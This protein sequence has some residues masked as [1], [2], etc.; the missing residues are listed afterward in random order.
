MP[1]PSRGE[2]KGR[3][4]SGP[5]LLSGTCEVE[6]EATMCLFKDEEEPLWRAV[7]SPRLHGQCVA[8]V[9]SLNW[10]CDR[11]TTAPTML[12]GRTFH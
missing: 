6:A 2:G 3:C 8:S 7:T 12:A 5:C 9:A 11:H 4:A 10:V 1:S